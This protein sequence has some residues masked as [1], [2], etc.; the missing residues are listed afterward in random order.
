MP[1]LLV[2]VT[3]ENDHPNPSANMVALELSPSLIESLQAQRE[4]VRKQSL[5]SVE[6]SIKVSDPKIQ[7]LF[8][9]DIGEE[10]L[11]SLPQVIC[12]IDFQAFYDAEKGDV[13]LPKVVVREDHF[14]VIAYDKFA[15]T[16]TL[17][18]SSI[19][20]FRALKFSGPGKVLYLNR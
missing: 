10:R 14:E 16:P 1:K 5:V 3:P 20:P 9:L 18:R 15:S 4:F 19:I 6:G 17:L 8:W 13:T 7:V 11:N 2:D 12:E